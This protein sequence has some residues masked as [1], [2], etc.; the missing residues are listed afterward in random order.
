MD[1]TFWRIPLVTM[2]ERITIVAILY[3]TKPSKLIICILADITSH[4][5][6]KLLTAWHL[7][8]DHV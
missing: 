6:P 8:H 3:P 1:C 7:G 5:L 4:A 2:G